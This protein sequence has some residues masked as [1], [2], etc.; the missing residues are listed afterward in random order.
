MLTSEEFWD[1]MTDKYISS[2]MEDVP[3]YERTMEKVA[4]YLGPEQQ[5]LE[6]GCGSGRTARRLAPLVAHVTATDFAPGMIARAA[7]EGK[8]APEQNL[9][10]L[11]ATAAPGGLPEGPFDAVLAFSVLHL[12]TDL[13][14]ALAAIRD[15]LKPGGLL[16]SKSVCFSGR[17]LAFRVIIGAMRLVN[18]APPLGFYASDRLEQMIVAA[19]FEIVESVAIPKGARNQ[20]IV[21]RKL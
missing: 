20:F 3:S 14:P 4:G 10:Y 5:V 2:P 9:T 11:R 6:I 16:I 19:G 1:R 18:K 8:G 21:A 12:I 7:E 17:A 13:P 15:S